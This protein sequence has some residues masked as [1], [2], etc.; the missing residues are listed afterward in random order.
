MQETLKQYA[1]AQERV[2]MAKQ[3]L[4]DMRLELGYVIR[5]TREKK[6]MKLVELARAVHVSPPFMYDVELGRRSVSDKVLELIS[7]ILI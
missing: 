7:K 4:D 2:R 3:G 6:G 1:S 5:R